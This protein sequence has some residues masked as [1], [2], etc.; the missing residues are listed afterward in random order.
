MA[1]KNQYKVIGVMSG[2]SLDGIDLVYVELIYENKHWK[3][4][5]LEAE[6][7]EYSQLWKERL[8]KALLLD[9]KQIL[10]LDERYTVHLASV[11]RQ[12]I[13]QYNLKCIDAVCSHGH[14]VFH[15]PDL[16]YTVQIGNMPILADLLQQ[17]V[18]CDFRV[19][20]VSLG[21]QGAPL[22]PIGDR[23]LFGEYQACLNL[24]GFAN[25]SF[26]NEQSRVAYDLVPVNVLLNEQAQKE[27]KAY[28]KNGLWAE[29]GKVDDN[30]LQELN[31]LEYYRELPPKSLGME[32]VNTSVKPILEKYNLSVC[33]F[34]ATLAEHI[35]MQIGNGI[36]LKNKSKVLVTG[37]GAHNNFLLYRIRHYSP[38][39]VF[40]KPKNLI[41]DYKE[42]LI[43]A[44]LGVLKLRNEVN[45]LA[46]VT[47]A[48]RDHSSGKIYD[49]FD[50]K[51]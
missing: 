29:R 1:M 37:G 25:I 7:I 31:S 45:V 51:Q 12:F 21:G 32:F 28:D 40:E 23:L 17:K 35:A 2:T 9:K 8:E 46:S 4:N 5:I 14:T 43:F 36:P 42:A 3:F 48:A 6:T 26:D 16:G 47:G 13:E 22:V 38:E 44:L 18:V 27:G 24:G 10:Q 49:F 11:I 19:E 30:L 39:L 34:L 50:E 15:R 33:D 20:D 41:I